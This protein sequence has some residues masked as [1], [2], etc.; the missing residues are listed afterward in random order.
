MA[1]VPV[2]RA[3]VAAFS[4]ASSL[5]LSTCLVSERSSAARVASTVACWR[6]RRITSWPCL[7]ATSAMP[8]PMIPEPTTPTRL[9]FVLAMARCYPAVADVK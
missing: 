7:A 2:T 9:T 6:E 5:P 3:S 8:A 4:S 1:A